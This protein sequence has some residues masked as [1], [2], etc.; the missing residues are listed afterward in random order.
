MRKS[1]G[2]LRTAPKILR[3][4][5]GVARFGLIQYEQTTVIV[6]VFHHPMSFPLPFHL[7]PRSGPY[8]DLPPWVDQNLEGVDFP[9]GYHFSGKFPL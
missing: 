5:A 4:A 8:V 7:S 1:L 6:L 9:R 2:R 3:R